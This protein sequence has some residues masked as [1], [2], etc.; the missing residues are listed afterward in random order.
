MLQVFGQKQSHCKTKA[1]FINY[2]LKD[3][4]WANNGQWG[5]GF[6]GGGPVANKSIVKKAEG[7]S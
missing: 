3:V 5:G 6:F 7:Q 1:G 2:L 4:P